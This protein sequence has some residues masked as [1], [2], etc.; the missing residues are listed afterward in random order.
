MASSSRRRNS[1]L[2]IDTAVQ[3]ERER[4]PYAM[5]AAP[6]DT[7]EKDTKEEPKPVKKPF[8]HQEGLCWVCD[9]YGFHF[10]PKDPP[11]DLHKK[12]QSKPATA[13]PKA[14]PQPTKAIAAKP[15]E[16]M[17]R[18]PARRMS[19]S[20]TRPVSMYVTTPV[21]AAYHQH[22]AMHPGWTAAALPPPPP[23]GVTYTSY[24]FMAPATPVGFIPQQPQQFYYDPQPVFE[25]HPQNQPRPPRRTSM[26]SQ[27]RPT[28]EKRPSRTNTM[29]ERTSSREQRPQ[30][31][32]HR[33]SKSIHADK[34]AMPPPAKPQHVT[35]IHAARP[36]TGRANTYHA[37]SSSHRRSRYE[38]SDDESDEEEIDPGALTSYK[39]PPQSPRRPPSSY[40]APTHEAPGRPQLAP[41]AKTYHDGSSAMHIAS[42]ARADG[43][44]RR[45]TTESVPAASSDQKAAAAEA[46]MRKRGSMPVNELTAENLNHLKNVATR[47][48]NDQRSESGSTNSHITHQSS[49]KDSSSGRGRIMSNSSALGHSKSTSMNINING[50]NLN[51]TDG[52]VAEAPPVR[53]DVAGVQ[54]SMNNREKENIDYFKRPQKQLERAPSMSSRPSRR[55]L[56]QS[57]LVSAAIDGLRREK[58]EMLAIEAARPS[59]D[60]SRRYSYVEE[61]ERE[62]LREAS[63]RSSRQASRNA[64]SVRPSIEELPVRPK[65][66]SHRSSVDYSRRDEPVM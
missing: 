52:G 54:I 38:E 2:K 64:S 40:K 47:Q 59:R 42:T 3:I 39:Q 48:V 37:N 26:I 19:T 29:L 41:K 51:I 21:Q 17:P 22:P 61:D 7:K 65:V 13:A 43:M 12:V 34:L 20:Q 49:S 63:A 10:D 57:S 32:S 62:A 60:S 1:G 5:T 16:D 36:R 9:R 4:K 6:H 66:Q 28:L 25:D 53:L 23:P 33:S 30:I 55:S 11:K 14:A 15:K 18:P 45:R 44:L 27:E 46:Y 50:L 35:T 8:C 56:T 24:P 58:D 31:V